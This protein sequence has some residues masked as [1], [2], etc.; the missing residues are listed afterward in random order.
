MVRTKET[1]DRVFH[2]ADNARP[3]IDRALHDEELRESVVRA[4]AA[5]RELYEE[6]ARPRT[7]AGVAQRLVRDDAVKTNLRVAV[8]EL[9]RAAD[10]LRAKEERRARTTVFLLAGAVLGILFNPWTGPETR[11]WLRERVGGGDETDL[12]GGGNSSSG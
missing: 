6:L 4:F 9:R 12:G 5:A 11:R 2:A 8:D 7:V 1:K 10:R 3:Y